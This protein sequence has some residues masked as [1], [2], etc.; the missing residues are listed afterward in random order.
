MMK[1]TKGRV[2]LLG[3]FFVLAVVL[4]GCNSTAAVPTLP[5]LDYLT[6]HLV[7]ELI[8]PEGAQ[9]LGGGGGGGNYGMGVET[10][11]T[12][13]LSLEQVN[14]HYADQLITRGWSLISEEESEQTLTSFWEVTDEG[15]T[16]WAG[17]LEVTFSPPNFPDTYRVKVAILLP[18]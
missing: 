7:P 4:V 12:S 14:Q 17:K 11:F 9:P 1:I 2:V 13:D 8:L 16:R 15:G 18:Q 6:E 5:D 3:L 10:F